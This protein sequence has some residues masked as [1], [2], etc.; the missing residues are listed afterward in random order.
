M[1]RFFFR[2]APSPRA[3]KGRC[4]GS[5]APRITAKLIL[6]VQT[7]AVINSTMGRGLSTLQLQ[8][9]A[10]LE[11]LSEEARPKDIMTMLNRESTN[12][13]RVA[14]SKALCRLVERGLVERGS[15][16]SDVQVLE[17]VRTL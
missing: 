4:D 13:N 15:A 11:Q 7:L 9:L 3:R 14:V 2:S 10:A 8:I 12:A 6:D 17:S 5:Q 1:R 16:L